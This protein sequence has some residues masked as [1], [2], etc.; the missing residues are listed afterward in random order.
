MTDTAEHGDGNVG[1]VLTR[2]STG[3]RRLE[4]R[5]D[6]F[7]SPIDL[8]LLQ[9]HFLP[10]QVLSA[11]PLVLG[12]PGNAHVVVLPFG[13]VV[14]WNCA[15]SYCL[16]V[17]NVIQGVLKAGPPSKEFRDT[18]LVLVD[19][20]EER[21]N[22]RDIRL[23]TLTLE[24]IRTI[25]E[26]F[27]RS[28]ALKQCELSVTQALKNTAPIVHALEA[29][30]AL[31]PSAKNLLKTV[32][33]TLAVREATLAGLSL[34]DDPA[35]TQQSE[36]LSRLHNLLNDYFDIKKRLA[37]LQEKV[38]F[39]SDLNQML[40][41]LLQNRTSHRLEVIVV[42]LIVIEVVFSFIHLFHTFRG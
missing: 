37:G 2:V 30:G 18:L 41:T 16:R 8:N 36:R 22:F 9:T 39:L 27:G 19:Q 32:G 28:V 15:E 38:T 34:F 40:M 42:V 31:A 5:A 26:S 11:D 23:K 24:H 13:A 33:F 25:S 1:T 14:F 20:P 3:T 21:V 17:L 7:N 10:S 29:R 35:E 12:L 6:Y 4:V